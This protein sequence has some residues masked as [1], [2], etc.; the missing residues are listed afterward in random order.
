[1]NAR[2]F[3]K[4]DAEVKNIYSGKKRKYLTINC[5]ACIIIFEAVTII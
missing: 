5:A 1:M 3:W 4:K 2:K